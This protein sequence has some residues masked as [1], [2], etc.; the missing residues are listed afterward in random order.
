[1]IKMALL[2]LLVALA[3]CCSFARKWPKPDER[4]DLERWR[5]ELKDHYLVDDEF[6][7]LVLAQL[8]RQKVEELEQRDRGGYFHRTLDGNLYFVGLNPKR[9]LISVDH[10]G[11]DHGHH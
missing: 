1:M 3:G 8:D 2:F 7:E 5:Q 9:K 6:A 10:K 4:T 11:E